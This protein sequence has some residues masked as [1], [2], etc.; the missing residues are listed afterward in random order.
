MLNNGGPDVMKH[1]QANMN[2][3]NALVENGRHTRCRKYS[4]IT[5]AVC[6]NIYDGAYDG[7]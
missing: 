7:G 4:F 1:I 5:R 6:I 2:D 3:Y